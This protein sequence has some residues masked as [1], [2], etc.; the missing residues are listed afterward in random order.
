MG[1]LVQIHSRRGRK[2]SRAGAQ[3]GGRVDIKKLLYT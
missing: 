2:F 1:V 3:L